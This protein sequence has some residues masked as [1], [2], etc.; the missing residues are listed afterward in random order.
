MLIVKRIVK[1]FFMY[2]SFLVVI[3]ILLYIKDSEFS[4]FSMQTQIIFESMTSF[5]FILVAMLVY[6]CFLLTIGGGIALSSQRYFSNTE[7]PKMGL[8]AVSIV[9]PVVVSRCLIAGFRDQTVVLVTGYLVLSFVFH[10]AVKKRFAMRL[11][12]LLKR[13]ALVFAADLI[14]EILLFIAVLFIVS[15]T[16]L[17]SLPFLRFNIDHTS[18]WYAR[19][20]FIVIFNS[21]NYLSIEYIVSILNIEIKKSHVKAYFLYHESALRRLW[22]IVR[23]SLPMILKKIKM[24]L[25]WLI[26]FIILFEMDNSVFDSIGQRINI[27][28]ENQQ[29]N[30]IFP[31]FIVIYLLLFIINTVFDIIIDKNSLEKDSQKQENEKNVKFHGSSNIL[32]TISALV[33]E[34]FFNKKTIGGKITAAIFTAFVAALL[35]GCFYYA[36][37]YVFLQ[38]Y[39]YDTSRNFTVRDVADQAF[40]TVTTTEDMDKKLCVREKKGL[41]NIYSVAEFSIVTFDGECMK[42]IP[43]MHTNVNNPD[44]PRPNIR[45]IQGG[46]VEEGGVHLVQSTLKNV[47]FG[48]AVAV[49]SI[50]DSFIPF[51][52]F[53]LERSSGSGPDNPNKLFFP[54]FVF[55]LFYLCLLIAVVYLVVV[56]VYALILHGKEYKAATALGNWL[57]SFIFATPFVI[58]LSV[59]RTFFPDGNMVSHIET[60]AAFP[61]VSNSLFINSIFSYCCFIAV[62]LLYILP[63]MIEDLSS[64]IKELVH[65]SEISYLNNIGMNKQDIFNVITRKYGVQNI[66]R[67]FV[68]NFL[69]ICVLQFFTAYCLQLNQFLDYFGTGSVLSFENVFSKVMRAVTPELIV[70]MSNIGKITEGAKIAVLHCVL[71]L[72]MYGSIYFLMKKEKR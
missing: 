23:T 65:S 10:A 31:V 9:P 69:F 59:L 62:L 52:P 29:L 55:Y 66:K 70:F 21:V 25:S 42:V 3:G 49:P 34:R 30:N 58:A 67:I 44:N 5:F 41:W 53:D 68:E 26:S 36:P 33:A 64:S 11:W 71:I 22:Y 6:L 2:L 45:V 72:A 57:K 28:A 4:V 32:K 39:G 51:I 20:F 50:F 8:Y 12:N 54:V 19:L 17:M 1:N 18:G 46:K 14:C 24:F 43:T 13:K 7:L 15:C 63:G 56:F 61:P 47:T 40:M 48:N 37:F 27:Q 60:L 35:W 16:P 38:H